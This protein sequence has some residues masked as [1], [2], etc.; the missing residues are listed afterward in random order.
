MDVE[1]KENQ[2]LKKKLRY[3]RICPVCKIHTVQVF[4]K[5]KGINKECWICK[6]CQTIVKE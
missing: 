5:I 6:L 4:K 1:K 3:D 2:I